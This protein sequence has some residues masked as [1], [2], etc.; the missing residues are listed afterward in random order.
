MA[1]EVGALMDLFN[2]NYGWGG[3]GGKLFNHNSSNNLH[4]IKKKYWCRMIKCNVF[5]TMNV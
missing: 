1:D 3:G 5:G 4:H 2:T